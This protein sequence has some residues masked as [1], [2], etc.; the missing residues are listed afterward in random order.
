MAMNYYL[1]YFDDEVLVHN[2]D[3][4]IDFLC[5]IREIDVTP[6]MEQEVRQYLASDVR[7][8]KR[9]KVR[10]HVY[11]II[12]KTDAGSME[13]F[14]DRRAGKDQHQAAQREDAPKPADRDSAAT[15]TALRREGFKPTHPA[16]AAMQ[17]A[18][19]GW[20]EG[21]LDFKRVTTDPRTGKFVYRDTRFVAQLK[22]QNPL[23][24]YQRI[25]AHLQQ[26]VDRRSQFPSVK[27]KNFQYKFLGTA[28]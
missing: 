18:R 20:Y 9:Y 28:K 25:V 26:R 17:E 6:I 7:F 8:P 10:P 5:G 19:P 15:A 22:A 27:G 1:R 13:E 12:I 24:C 11:F 23:D 2:A 4:A 3:E 21:S 16:I 14:K